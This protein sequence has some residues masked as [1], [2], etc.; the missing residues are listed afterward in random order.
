MLDINKT[1][2]QLIDELAG[3]RQRISD[4]EKSEVERKRAEAALKH[5]EERYRELVEKADIAILIDD[6][7]GNI[8][9]FNKKLAKLF[10]YSMEEIKNKSI[11]FT[12]HP[13]D[14]DRVMGFH[15]KRIQGRKVPSRYEFK[16]IKKDGTPLYLEVNAVKLKDKNN[17]IGTRSYMWD[18]TDRKKAE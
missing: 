4:L 6:K 9:Y 15:K 2:E 11:E 12:V 3:L 10:G 17:I 13:D 8:Q 7:E 18:I 16:G 1:K 14:I 5:S